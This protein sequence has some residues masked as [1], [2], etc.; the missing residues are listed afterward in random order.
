MRII[1]SASGLTAHKLNAMHVDVVIM[2]YETLEVSL[3][4]VSAYTAKLEAWVQGCMLRSEE[5]ERP[6]DPFHSETWLDVRVSQSPMVPSVSTATSFSSGCHIL[7]GN[8]AK[9]Q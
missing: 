2:S 5:L 4:M 9:P 1:E 8:T 3:R 6:K 7:E